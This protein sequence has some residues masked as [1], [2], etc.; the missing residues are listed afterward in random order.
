MSKGV[1]LSIRGA[2]AAVQVHLDRDVIV[3][4]ASTSDVWLPFD[5]VSARHLRVFA[6]NGQWFVEDLGST[7]G[8]R[9]SAGPITPH[10]PISIGSKLE[11]IIQDL[12]LEFSRSVPEVVAFTLGLS[13]S[14]A[15]Q[16]AANMA[17]PTGYAFIEAMDGPAAGARIE[18][19]DGLEGVGIRIRGATLEFSDDSEH[20]V[21]RDGEGFGLKVGEKPARRLRSGERFDLAGSDVAFFDP[22]EAQLSPIPEPEVE[23]VE[24]H[25]PQDTGPNFQDGESSDVPGKKIPL[26]ALMV[27]AAVVGVA[28]LIL[29]LFLV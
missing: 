13:G 25:D 26:A 10:S 1:T 18:L 5:F 17:G 4:R 3:G 14:I 6:E 24:S 7:N 22:L 12:E 2:G 8:T 21:V 20:F 15:R 28:V 23:P 11:L 9:S 27:L 29:S 19:Q 16:L